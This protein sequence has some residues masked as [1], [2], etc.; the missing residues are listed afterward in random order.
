M[1]KSKIV[2]QFRMKL[3]D[4][5]YHD[6]RFDVTAFRGL[7]RRLPDRTLVY[8]ADYERRLQEYEAQAKAKTE[9]SDERDG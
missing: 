5:I 3:A 1:D 4:R 6:H 2:G 7:M 9:A 8:T